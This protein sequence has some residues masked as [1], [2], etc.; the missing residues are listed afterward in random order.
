[1]TLRERMARAIDPKAWINDGYYRI[2]EKR[3]TL[4][5]KQADACLRAM[6]EP[7]DSMEIA[8]AIAR[9]F[10]GIK[11]PSRKR[12]AI[13]WQAMIDAALSE[14]QPTSKGGD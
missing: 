9:D 14:G 6:Q 8:G 4:S 10:D 11:Y 3:R 13:T 5:L 1:M 12:A 2:F 7:T